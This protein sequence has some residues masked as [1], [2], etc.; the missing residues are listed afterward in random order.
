MGEVARDYAG[1]LEERFKQHLFDL[2]FVEKMKRWLT[3]IQ[4][5][6][7]GE[8]ANSNSQSQHLSK[9]ISVLS[10]RVELVM[11]P[12]AD[13]ES[14]SSE[15]LHE[16]LMPLVVSIRERV[17]YLNCALSKESYQNA[18]VQDEETKVEIPRETSKTPKSSRRK[19]RYTKKSQSSPSG[20]TGQ[21]SNHGIKGH[22]ENRDKDRTLTK[23]KSPSNE[24]KERKAS[25]KDQAAANHESLDLSRGSSVS[26]GMDK[27][28]GMARTQFGGKYDK[29]YLI[30]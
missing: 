6:I 28:Q 1:K 9:M 12:S 26:M 16:T 8:V 25:T 24:E 3:N 14:Y 15:A 10:R 29:R 5:K 4:V 17:T 27:R 18:I 23:S 19:T 22:T 20:A 30:F 21:R 2:T 7:K 13:G 11:N